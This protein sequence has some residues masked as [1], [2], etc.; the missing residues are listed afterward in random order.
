LDLAVL[1]LDGRRHTEESLPSLRKSGAR[2]K[3]DWPPVALYWKKPTD[4]E[5]ACPV[6]STIRVTFTDIS[7]SHLAIF[8]GIVGDP[9]RLQLHPALP[10]ELVKFVAAET[11]F[12]MISF[13][14]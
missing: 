11:V 1:H 10:D 8:I 2:A 5:Q 12:F 9:E 14:V 6:K 4:S 3:S 13:G 7:L